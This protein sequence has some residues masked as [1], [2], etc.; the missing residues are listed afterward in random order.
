M[1]SNLLSIDD[2]LIQSN[3]MMYALAAFTKNG[4]DT[5]K[6]CILSPIYTPKYI[7]K[8]LP[9]TRIL[10]CEIDPLRDS[11][12]YFALKLKK[13]GVDT[14]LYFLKEFIH[15]FLC[16]DSQTFGINEYRK[17]SKIITQ[18]IKELLNLS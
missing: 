10:V 8:M 6:N 1:P 3:L 13:A 16:F 5:T 17:G 9:P 12:I 14:K 18:C 11:G 2:M 15:A 4:G 7:L